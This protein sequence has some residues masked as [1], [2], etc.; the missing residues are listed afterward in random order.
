MTFRHSTNRWFSERYNVGSAWGFGGSGGDLGSYLV[1]YAF[2]VG[3][4]TLL[5]FK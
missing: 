4:V 2:Q 5:K 3:A 1:N